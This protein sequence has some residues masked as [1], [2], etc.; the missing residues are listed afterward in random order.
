MKRLLWAFTDHTKNSW[1]WI[2]FVFRKLFCFYRSDCWSGVVVSGLTFLWGEAISDLPWVKSAE[3]ILLAEGGAR[4]GSRVSLQCSS[5]QRG[6]VL[7]CGT[8][9]RLRVSCAVR[10]S[11][12]LFH[13]VPVHLGEGRQAEKSGM[14]RSLGFYLDS[15]GPYTDQFYSL[16]RKSSPF[17]HLKQEHHSNSLRVSCLWAM[18]EWW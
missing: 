9:C 4:P 10:V 16:C 3:M 7:R 13:S 12:A 8:C 15:S 6:A 2:P 1:T 14:C 11:A 17:P 18:K 5:G